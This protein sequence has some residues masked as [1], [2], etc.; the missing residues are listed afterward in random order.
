MYYTHNFLLK[1]SLN[2]TKSTAAYVTSIIYFFY[3]VGRFI[4][5][6]VSIKVGIKQM[7]YFNLMLMLISNILISFAIEHNV[8]I[9]YL[10]FAILGFS[11]SSM[12]PSFI[13]YFEHR[14]NMTMRV[15]TLL[16]ASG[17]HIF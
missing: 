4:N 2:L 13:S 7:I 3:G 11:Y 17:R 8:W 6:F 16:V 10:A 1:T 9:T 14:L 5:I 12:L 15:S